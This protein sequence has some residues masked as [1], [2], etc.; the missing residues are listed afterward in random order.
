MIGGRPG[1]GHSALHALSRIVSQ[2]RLIGSADCIRGGYPVVSFTAVP[3]PQLAKRRIYRRH[4]GRW[5]FEPY[6]LSIDRDW[7]IDRGAQ[8]V[9]YGRQQDWPGLTQ[10]QRPLFQLCQTTDGKVDWTEEQEWRVLHSLDLR[11]LPADRGLVFVPT[12]SAA[13]Q[14]AAISRWPVTVLQR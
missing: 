11:H 14:I 13:D 5:D 9:I 3:L 2:Q 1:S 4:L 10:Q 6:G 12:E 7:L 8:P